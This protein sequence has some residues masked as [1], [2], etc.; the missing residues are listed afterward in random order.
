MA[1]SSS[2]KVTCVGSFVAGVVA[3]VS[4]FYLCWLK[5]K[6]PGIDDGDGN[7]GKKSQTQAC[8]RQQGEPV[9]DPYCLTASLSTQNKHG[10][11]DLNALSPEDFANAFPA[12]WEKCISQA[13]KEDR[14]F[15]LE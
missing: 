3:G 10:G 4:L 1:G 14:F 5:K 13:K 9:V 15:D 6:S 8:S 7:E 12:F 11:P 2:S